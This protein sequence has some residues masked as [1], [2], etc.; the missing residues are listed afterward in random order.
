M[1]EIILPQ[2]V[3]EDLKEDIKNRDIKITELEK[4]IEKLKERIELL[5]KGLK[6]AHLYVNLL[7]DS[8]DTAKAYAR[9]VEAIYSIKQINNKVGE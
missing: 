7:A 2:K 6:F 9:A 8:E 1:S 3:Y 5:D 4:K